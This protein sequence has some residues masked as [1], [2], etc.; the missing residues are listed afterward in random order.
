MSERKRQFEKGVQVKQEVIHYDRQTVA[1]SEEESVESQSPDLHLVLAT[2]GFVSLG[3]LWLGVVTGFL[4]GGSWRPPFLSRQA[5]ENIHHATTVLGLSLGAVHGIGQLAVPDGSITV[6]ELVVPFA[7]SDDRIGTGLAV[8]GAEVLAAVG[9][10]MTV[11]RWLG[12]E[13]WLWLHRFSYVAFMLIVAH[14]LVSGTEVTS[15]WA[16]LPLLV[17]WLATAALWLAAMSRSR[18]TPPDV[19]HRTEVL[20]PVAPRLTGRG[21]GP[22][23]AVFVDRRLCTGAGLCEQLAPQVFRLD[24]DGSVWQRPTVHVD[25][26]QPVTRAAESCPVRAITLAHRPALQAAS[27]LSIDAPRRG[28]I[29]DVPGVRRRP[30]TSRG[31]R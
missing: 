13:R 20:R 31:L 1:A 28:D 27:P 26:L 16:W 15:V 4:L 24:A 5:L 23:V 19:P 17:G 9:L 29:S 21:H 6:V 7:D 14:A 10:S 8:V 3:L 25:D 12:P 2:L 22:D 11:Q 30:P 18:T